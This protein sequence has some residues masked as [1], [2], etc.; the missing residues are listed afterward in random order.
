MIKNLYLRTYSKRLEHR[1]MKEDLMDIFFLKEELW[2]CWLEEMKKKKT[3]PWNINELEK[4][5]KSLKSNKTAD[6]HGLVNEIFKS[7]CAGS[8]LVESLL[9]LYNGIKKSFHIPRYMLLENITTVLKKKGSRFDL[10]ND[11]GIFILTV[12]KKILDGLIY[13]DNVENIDKKMSDSNIGARRNKSIKNHLFIIYGVI[14]SVLKDNLECIDI[15]IYDLQKA[16][17]ALWL[18]DCMNDL[19]DILE[20]PFR[21][22]KIA[23][24]YESNKENLVAVKTAVGMTDRVNVPQIVQQGGTWGP[25][26]CSNTVDTLG[27]KCSDRGELHYL[28][29]DTVRVLPLAMVE[30]IN[31]ISKCGLD[32]VA[33]NT[34]INTQIELK[35]LKFHVPDEKGRSKC[36][37]LHIGPRKSTCPELKVHNT[38]MVDVTEDTYLGDII[39]A[40]GKNTK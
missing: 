21:N 34:F 26:L 16:F 30:D 32:S 1:K 5:L 37:K 31:G 3:E 17:D 19:H 25:V 24:L 10:N 33:L 40:N 20:K 18:N 29:K 8:D 35:K 13:L 39:S 7:N 4:A 12:F 11:R 36:H 15:Q 14:N 23:L 9:L 38:V 28:Y 2:S 22:D 27:K 6:P